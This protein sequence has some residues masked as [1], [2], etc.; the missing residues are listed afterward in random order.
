MDYWMG[1]CI[2]FALPDKCDQISGMDLTH[3]STHLSTLR[4]CKS[5]VFDQ[6]ICN[7]VTTLFYHC[8]N[9]REHFS[10]IAYSQMKLGL[11]KIVKSDDMCIRCL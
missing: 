5:L 9:M 8:T 11:I 2:H 3:P 10:L 6:L 7:L 1:Q 4:K